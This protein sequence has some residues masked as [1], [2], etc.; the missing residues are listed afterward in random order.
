MVTQNMVKVI[1]LISAVVFSAIGS[2][3]ITT[4]E[5]QGNSSQQI[6]QTGNQSSGTSNSTSSNSTSPSQSGGLGY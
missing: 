6:N 4:A 3:I 2:G 1:F 5:A